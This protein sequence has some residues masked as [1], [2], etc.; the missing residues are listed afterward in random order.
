M[1]VR[2]V[3]RIGHQACFHHWVTVIP[4]PLL[5]RFVL[6]LLI[7]LLRIRLFRLISLPLNNAARI[8]PALSHY[9][10]L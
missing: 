7:A 6:F 5:I 8:C 3:V 1:I 4:A 9:I 2:L 10:P